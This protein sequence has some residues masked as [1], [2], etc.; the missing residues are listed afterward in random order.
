MY[1]FSNYARNAVS[2][3]EKVIMTTGMPYLNL[4]ALGDSKTNYAYATCT[5]SLLESFN[6]PFM[7]KDQNPNVVTGELVI[8][9]PEFTS[10]CPVT[11]QP[12]FATIIISYIPR[13][14]CLESKSL[15]LYLNSYRHYGGFHESCV[16]KIINDIINLLDPWQIT[17]TGEFSPRGGIP[18]HPTCRYVRVKD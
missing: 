10:I 15:K 5:A 18:F 17:V 11:G 8:R 14:L 6:S 9:C 3:L 4:K 12:D 7:N 13:N 2:Q 16:V 1:N